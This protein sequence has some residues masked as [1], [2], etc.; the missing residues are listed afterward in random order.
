MMAYRARS[1]VIKLARPLS[2][3]PT[4]YRFLAPR[5]CKRRPSGCCHDGCGNVPYLLQHVGGQ[6]QH[7]G[8]G[9]ERLRRSQV[10]NALQHRTIR[11]ATSPPWLPLHT[12]LVRV[13][14][15]GHH[16]NHLHS[17]HRQQ[18]GCQAEQLVLRRTLNAAH[19]MSKPNICSC[20]DRPPSGSVRVVEAGSRHR[21]CIRK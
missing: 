2:A 14:L 9:V 10:A 7:V 17:R 11:V 13:L 8:F 3:S 5:L 16:F 4:S 12:D 6:H 19:E 20:N 1:G 18:C 15:A 21:G